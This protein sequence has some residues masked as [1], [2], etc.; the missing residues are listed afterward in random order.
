MRLWILA[1][2]LFIINEKY[3]NWSHMYYVIMV[4]RLIV[5][6]SLL[7]NNWMVKNTIKNY[8]ILVSIIFNC[9]I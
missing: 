9:N 1:V 6:L 2:I 4:N 7:Y 5:K 3:C 8:F